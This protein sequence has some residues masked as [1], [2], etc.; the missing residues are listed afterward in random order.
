MDYLINLAN[1]IGIY[2]TELLSAN[3]TKIA[4]IMI[5]PRYELPLNL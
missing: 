2:A 5:G 4:Q 1:Q 3:K